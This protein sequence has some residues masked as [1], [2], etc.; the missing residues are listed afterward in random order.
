M[1]LI[2][3]E[4]QDLCNGKARGYDLTE[5]ENQAYVETC[6]SRDANQE[7]LR[8][9]Y[10]PLTTS[11]AA[12][13]GCTAEGWSVVQLA[14]LATIG[15]VDMAMENAMLIPASAF[16]FPGRNGH[17]M[18]N[19]LHYMATRPRGGTCGRVGAGFPS[20]AAGGG[21]CLL[22]SGLRHSRFVHLCSSRHPYGQLHVS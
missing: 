17:S 9:I 8:E 13:S 7:W 15:N 11:C 10:A 18:T 5:E 2:A 16:N 12:D 20:A 21:Q 4:L 19:T 6:R 14:I 3:E 22:S 1:L